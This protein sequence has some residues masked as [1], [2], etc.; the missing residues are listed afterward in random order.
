MTDA[1]ANIACGQDRV[2]RWI[3]GDANPGATLGQDHIYGWTPI[4]F[5]QGPGSKRC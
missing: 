1:D 5:D 4:V 2:A 3:Y